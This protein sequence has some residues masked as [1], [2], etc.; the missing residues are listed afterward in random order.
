M[1]VCARIWL[2]VFLLI[3]GFVWRFT[4]LGA[5][6]LWNRRLPLSEG[7]KNLKCV[8][9]TVFLLFLWIICKIYFA[10][11]LSSV[12]N[13]KQWHL[14]HFCCCFIYSRLNF[15]IIKLD[16]L[17][18]YGKS[19]CVPRKSKMKLDVTAAEW[20]PHKSHHLLFAVAVSFYS[21]HMLSA[22]ICLIVICSYFVH[23]CNLF[24][25]SLLFKQSIEPR[26]IC[27]IA[28]MLGASVQMPCRCYI[29]THNQVER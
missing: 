7:H 23:V 22:V 18:N 1:K 13:A 4:Q 12:Q 24:P 29:W 10:H 6:I 8:M 19:V 28:G 21:F 5:F 20:N 17:P 3:E 25:Q 15:D 14:L 9:Q 11:S 2:M 26:E 27:P 16:H